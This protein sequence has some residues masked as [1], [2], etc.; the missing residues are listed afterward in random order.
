MDYGELNGS[1]KATFQ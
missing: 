1:F